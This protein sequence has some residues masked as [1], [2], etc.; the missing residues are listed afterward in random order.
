MYQGGQ[1][2]CCVG[3]DTARRL[4]NHAAIELFLE[5][6]IL[7]LLAG[8]MAESLND[9]KVDTEAAADVLMIGGGK[10][11]DGKISELIHLLR[12]IRYADLADDAAFK[13]A[14]SAITDELWN[15]A[16]TLVEAEHEVISAFAQELDSKVER[17]GEEYIFSEEDLQ[18]LLSGVCEDGKG[19]AEGV[20]SKH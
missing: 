17:G 2:D 14:A 13:E 8:A 7:T 20:R 16:R 3:N 9:G 1:Y 11:D 19:T 18:A 4:S 10:N 6:R 12:N 15:K 5:D